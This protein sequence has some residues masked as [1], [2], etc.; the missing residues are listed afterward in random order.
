MLIAGIDVGSANTKAVIYDPVQDRLVSSAVSRTGMQPRVAAE[1]TLHQA[2]TRAQLERKDLSRI[3]ATGYARHS[4]TIADQTVTEITAT[5]RG[6]RHWHPRCQTIIDIGG[7][8]SKVISLNA[9]GL[10]QDFVMN[11]RCA[12]G[13]GSFLEFIA[14]SLDIPIEQFGELS[15]GS[16]Q[17]VTISSLCVVMAETEILS[18]TAADTPRADI[19]AGLHQALAQRIATLAARVPVVPEVLFT[20]GTALNTGM[21]RALTRTLRLPVQIARFPLLAAAFGAALSS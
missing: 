17:P 15:A 8:D 2:L 5:A 21:Q 9:E 6:I 1:K 12:A 14:R 18:L 4:V 11:D 10:V 3:C 7:Q 16:Q 20:G 13:T 19:I